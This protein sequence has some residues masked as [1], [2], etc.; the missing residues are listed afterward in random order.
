[1]A[2]MPFHHSFAFLCKFKSYKAFND[3]L[4]FIVHSRLKYFNK[5]LPCLAGLIIGSH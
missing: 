3:S 5:S 4:G 2:R 1:M